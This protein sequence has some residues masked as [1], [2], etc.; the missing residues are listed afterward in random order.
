M[1]KIEKNEIKKQAI[2]NNTNILNYYP[3]KYSQKDTFLIQ[4]FILNLKK[5][6][7]N[8]SKNGIQRI[9]RLRSECSQQFVS[10]R[11]QKIKANIPLDEA[12]EDPYSNF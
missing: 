10:L 2:G 7:G 1:A 4:S 6:N 11:N 5:L 8:W 12:F 3:P 9:V